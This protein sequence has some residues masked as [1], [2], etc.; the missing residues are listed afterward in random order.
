VVRPVPPAAVA[1][2]S[3]TARAAS[4]AQ[5]IDVARTALG[6]RWDEVV[7]VMVAS[8]DI[9]AMVKELAMQ[10]ELSAIEPDGAGAPAEAWV[11]TV[12]RETLRTTTLSDKLLVVLRSVTG[13]AGLRLTLMP[14]VAQDSPARR[15]AE[16][17]AKRQFEAEQTIHAD[18]L[19]QAMLAQFSTARIVPG[20]IKPNLPDNTTKGQIP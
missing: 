11:L 5:M 4:A 9:A 13:L 17:A 20:S 12:E 3:P 6:D 18:P 19:V 16:H 7:K 10:A 14:G 15:D 1:T 8:G 2:A